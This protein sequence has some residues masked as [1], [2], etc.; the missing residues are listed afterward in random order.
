M[1]ENGNI[2]FLENQSFISN[3]FKP[4]FFKKNDENW[5]IFCIPIKKK[6]TIK[7]QM[8]V[9]FLILYLVCFLIIVLVIGVI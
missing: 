2:S 9:S 5:N 1:R 8:I 7:T 4:S 6:W 3:F